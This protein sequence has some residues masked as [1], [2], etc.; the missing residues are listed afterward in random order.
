MFLLLLLLLLCFDCLF[1]THIISLADWKVI[2]TLNS[3][4]EQNMIC[5]VLFLCFVRASCCLF[6]YV[7]VL[8]AVVFFLLFSPPLFIH[9][10]FSLSPS[11]CLILARL[12]IACTINLIYAVVWHT[13]VFIVNEIHAKEPSRWKIRR[14][15]EH[16]SEYSSCSY[17]Q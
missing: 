3:T 10:F 17:T 15:K 12:F 4:T 13:V 9:I 7:R 16:K 6:N 11:A 5:I 1:R 14:K 2:H 8:W